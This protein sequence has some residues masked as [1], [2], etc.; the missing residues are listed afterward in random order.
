MMGSV[1]LM[2]SIVTFWL[3][4]SWFSAARFRQK[5]EVL[6]YQLAIAGM[7]NDVHLLTA[8]VHHTDTGTR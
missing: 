8:W 2:L 7:V 6:G 4:P 1:A 3:L 5:N